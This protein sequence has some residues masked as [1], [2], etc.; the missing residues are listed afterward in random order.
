MKT[1]PARSIIDA[2]EKKKKRQ[3]QTKRTKAFDSSVE[4]QYVR[5]PL[6]KKKLVLQNRSSGAMT[7]WQIVQFGSEDEVCLEFFLINV[8]VLSLA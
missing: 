1:F 4:S 5:G 3:L 8:G 6:Q 2:N 7:I